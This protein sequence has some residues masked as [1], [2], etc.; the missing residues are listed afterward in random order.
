MSVG[1]WHVRLRFRM[2]AAVFIRQWAGLG[3]APQPQIEEAYKEAK[4]PL[5]AGGDGELS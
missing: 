5:Q 1:D 2:I 3:N 4:A